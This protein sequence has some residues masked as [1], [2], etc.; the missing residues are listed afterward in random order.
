MVIVAEMVTRNRDAGKA[1][2]ILDE[3][4]RAA[5]QIARDSEKSTRMAS[6]AIGVAKIHQYRQAREIADLCLSPS[7]KLAAYTAIFQNYLIER[8]PAL[9]KILEK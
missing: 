8:D 4:Q 5:Q 6:V 7:H 2:S 9:E 1:R 3:A